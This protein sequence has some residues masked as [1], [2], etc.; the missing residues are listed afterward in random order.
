MAFITGKDF[1]NSAVKLR[2]TQITDE[3]LYHFI[4][5]ENDGSDVGLAAK[6][7]SVTETAPAT[8]TASSGLNGRLQRVAQRLTSLL[9]YGG[10]LAAAIGSGAILC[11]LS[12]A[13]TLRQMTG[14][15]LGSH[16]A[17]TV[18]VVDASGNQVTA[19]GGV[20][21][22]VSTHHIV[23]AASTNAA[24]I[25]A[26]AGTVYGVS[27]F[28]NADYPVKVCLHN[29][30]G[31]PTAG[32]S[33]VWSQVVQAGQRLDVVI[34]QGGRAFATGIARTV[35]KIA[36][37]GDMADSGA[38]ATAANDAQFEVSYV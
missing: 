18:A 36:A 30:A 32:A 35:V 33:V 4:P 25:K 7:G 13:G 21:G 16:F 24:N 14:L 2:T 3:N 20:A 23:T 29:T 10:S 38:T 22:T 1:N 37:A 26:S 15:A 9:S 5:K 6:L 12:V 17:Q 28:N 34:P 19:F 11:G 8:D 31:T 27:G